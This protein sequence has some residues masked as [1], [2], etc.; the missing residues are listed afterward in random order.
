M[1]SIL[2]V[3][4]PKIL[5]LA[6]AKWIVEKIKWSKTT[7]SFRDSTCWNNIQHKFHNKKD[8]RETNM[9]WKKGGKVAF[10]NLSKILKK[11]TRGRKKKKIKKNPQRYGK[12]LFKAKEEIKEKLLK[13]QR[14]YLISK[15]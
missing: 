4:N 9:H 3:L 2:F 1:K 13:N 12:V 6:K 5:H 14:N 15:N 10:N 11:I 7:F 8:V